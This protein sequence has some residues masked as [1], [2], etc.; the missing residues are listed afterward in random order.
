[1]S[2]NLKFAPV[3]SKAAD[4]KNTAVVF[5]AQSQAE[6][7][8]VAFAAQALIDGIWSINDQGEYS[9][10]GVYFRNDAVLVPGATGG[11][12]MSMSATPLTGALTSPANPSNVGT[13]WR[14][15]GPSFAAQNGTLTISALTLNQ[16]GGGTHL[17][18]KRDGIVSAGVRSG[19]ADNVQIVN[20]LGARVLSVTGG[21]GAE[22]S[23]KG[24]VRI[25]GNSVGVTMEAVP[26]LGGASQAFSVNASGTLG[27]VFVNGGR[28]YIPGSGFGA[29]RMG[30]IG[31]GTPTAKLADG[32]I[33][34]SDTECMQVYT[35]N[36]G[37]GVPPDPQARRVLTVTHVTN[38][39]S[40][41][42]I[43]PTSGTTGPLITTAPHDGSSSNQNPDLRL[44]AA[45]SGSVVFLNNIRMRSGT[46]V[47]LSTPTPATGDI[48]FVSDGRKPTE[49]SGSGTGVVCQWLT[50]QW[51]VL[52][53]LDIVT[54]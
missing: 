6:P 2:E 45:G 46:K 13:L 4:I 1:M 25:T 44:G 34:A 42:V 54:T 10:S 15:I 21:V 41:V 9:D 7:N 3:V 23:T 26:V 52:N 17:T 20:A 49:G 39:E 22:D 38:P 47:A 12:F 40:R 33:G 28:V 53:T 14:R 8:T 43:T 5:G 48:A 19:G 29:I 50:G 27:A 36:S 31:I 11:Y 35:G 18:F 30:F 24:F 51:R 32:F 37:T 16:N